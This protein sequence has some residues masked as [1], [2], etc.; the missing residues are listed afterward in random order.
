[1]DINLNNFLISGLQIGLHKLRKK[2]YKTA[3]N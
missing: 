2:P 1:M 3:E